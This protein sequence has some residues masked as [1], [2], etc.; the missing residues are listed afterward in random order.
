M[1]NKEEII[2]VA[3]IDDHDLLRNGVC[4]FLNSFGFATIFEVENGLLAL[5]KIERSHLM[6]D[7]CIVDINMPVM[8][9]FELTKILRRKYPTIKII[10]FSVNDDEKDVIKMLDCGADG[11]VLKGADPKELEE[12]VKVV[13]DC[14]RYFS[15]GVT[16]IAEHYFQKQRVIGNS[17]ILNKKLT[18]SS[19]AFSPR[20]WNML[21]SLEVYTIADIVAIPLKDFEKYRGFK[22]MCKLEL[23]A[24][25]EFEGIEDLFDDFN[26]WKLSSI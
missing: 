25:I 7:V 12:A 1:S 5:E 9:G 15:A 6:P 19:F 10:A 14:G 17:E 21:K 23:E 8:D 3:I 13:Y 26:K 11:Y 22:K 20:L 2:R 18:D 4:Q 16:T 24:F